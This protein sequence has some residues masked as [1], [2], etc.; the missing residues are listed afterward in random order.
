MFDLLKNPRRTHRGAADHDAGDPGF[1]P[2]PRDIRRSRHVAI[3]DDR[4]C[5]R[6]DDLADHLPIRRAGVTLRARAAVHGDR[7]DAEV[8]QNPRDARGA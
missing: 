2:P 5:D 1:G 6:G 7:G 4:N 8:F 3:A